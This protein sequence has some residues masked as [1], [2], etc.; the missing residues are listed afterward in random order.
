MF[1]HV[2]VH[3]VK[4]CP[5]SITGGGGTIKNRR[6]EVAFSYVAENSDELSLEPGEVFNRL[7]QNVTIDTAYVFTGLN[8]YKIAVKWDKK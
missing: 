3:V 8:F 2:R 4:L 5:C 1:Y 7:Y 6:A